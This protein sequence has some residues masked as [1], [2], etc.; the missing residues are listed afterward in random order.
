VRWAKR[1]ANRVS[2]YVLQT[3]PQMPVVGLL[4]LTLLNSAPAMI[5]LTFAERL[6]RTLELDCPSIRAL[7]V[8]LAR[9]G[10]CGGC[11]R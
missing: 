6:I 3:V 8:G 1:F 2:P 4:A 7:F 9:S 10:N 11:G 5:T